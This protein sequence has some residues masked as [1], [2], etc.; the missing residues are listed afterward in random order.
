MTIIDKIEKSIKES[1]GLCFYYD[2][3]DQLNEMLDNA[4]FPCA[5]AQL[6]APSGA[7]VDKLG[8]YHERVTIE[9]FFDDITEEGIGAKANERVIDNMKRL[10]LKW[11]TDLR[12]ND[13]L[14]LVGDIRTDR[15]YMTRAESD[16]VISTG[17]GVVVTFEEIDGLGGC[18]L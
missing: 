14:R 7:V 10:A 6:L 2:D 16:D 18:E 15:H 9:V 8:R 13:Y 12:M 1:T 4:T 3:A 11:L 17:Y 5:A